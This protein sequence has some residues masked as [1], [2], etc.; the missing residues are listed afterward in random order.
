LGGKGASSATDEKK[1][2]IRK[3]SAWRARDPKK[4]DWKY[5]TL[6]RSKVSKCDKGR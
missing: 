4:R 6:L 1:R 2:F 5:K 3:I